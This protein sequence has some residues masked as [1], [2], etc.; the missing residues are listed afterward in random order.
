[1]KSI[2]Q[3]LQPAISAI[4]AAGGE[5]VKIPLPSKVVTFLGLDGL[6]T[7]MGLPIDGLFTAR[8]SP[9][10][11]RYY[12]AKPGVW[13][14][15]DEQVIILFGFNEGDMVYIPVLPGMYFSAGEHSYLTPF[16]QYQLEVRL[17][18]KE[19]VS[20]NPLYLGPE[21]LSDV[22]ET[23]GSGNKGLYLK[24]TDAVNPD[25]GR[26]ELV[27]T[28]VETVPGKFPRYRVTGMCNGIEGSWIVSEK[29]GQKLGTMHCMGVTDFSLCMDSYLGRKFLR[30][31]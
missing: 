14:T 31:V 19:G 8:W 24:L 23:L 2:E 27:L 12:F 17:K 22:L 13:K 11:G 15:E 16:G 25:L 3:L 1:M 7:A 5:Y 6:E 4:P 21:G 18:L 9:D 28:S 10:K 29:L 30:L 20:A 26:Q